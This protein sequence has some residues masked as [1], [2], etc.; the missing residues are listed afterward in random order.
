MISPEGLA[1]DSAGNLYTPNF[2]NDNIAKINKNGR[3]SIFTGAGLK[4][5]IYIAIQNHSQPASA[6]A[7]A[8]L[9]CLVALLLGIIFL[10]WRRRQLQ[11]ICRNSE[12]AAS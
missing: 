9:G 10:V 1:F 11:L 2:W 3:V 7:L 4:K 6:L 5:P 12:A 8:F